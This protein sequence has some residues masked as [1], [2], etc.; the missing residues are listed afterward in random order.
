MN[1]MSVE[2]EEEKDATS[3]GFLSRR[4]MGAPTHPKMI[5]LVMKAGITKTDKGAQ[6]FLIG[7]IIAAFVISIVIF[8]FFVLGLTPKSLWDHLS[9]KY[10][11]QVSKPPPT[12]LKNLPPDVRSRIDAIN[13]QK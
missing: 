11:S 6:F 2:F 5:S 13:A 12:L 1:C 8:F 9:G 4:I 3:G 10:P 7:T